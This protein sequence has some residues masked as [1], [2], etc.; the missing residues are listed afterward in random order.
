[1]NVDKVIGGMPKVSD[2]YAQLAPGRIGIDA[3]DAIEQATF[4]VNVPILDQA[5]DLDQGNL[6]NSLISLTK[7]AILEAEAIEEESKPFIILP[8]PV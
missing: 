6:L 5:H 3:I 8:Q 2:S 1:M 7:P 4:K